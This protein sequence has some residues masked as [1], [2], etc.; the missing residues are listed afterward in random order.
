MS[1]HFR[2]NNKETSEELFDKRL[3]YDYYVNPV[4]DNLV[5]FSFAEKR[6]Y[7]RVNRDY[8]PIY[9]LGSLPIRNIP[10][11]PGKPHSAINF[12]SDA[13]AALQAEFV[14]KAAQG[15]IDTGTK[16]LSSL[17]VHKSYESPLNLY[18]KYY[19][20]YME[21]FEEVVREERILFVNFGQ[22]MNKILPY[23]MSAA[24]DN[25]FTFPGFLKSKKCSV[26]ASGLAIEIADIP[27]DNDEKKYEEFLKSNN[28][29]F[30]V[31]ACAN[32]G[33]MVDRH[34]PYR[35]VADIASAPML[36]YAQV[37]GAASTDEVLTAGFSTAHRQY[38]SRFKQIMFDFYER[39][40]VQRIR[41]HTYVNNT[42]RIVTYEPV[43]YTLD[44]ISE[45]YTDIY[46]LQ[47][48][49]KLR[50]SEE[51][52]NHTP[53]QRARLIQQT[54]SLAKTDL[55]LALD[56]FEIILNKPFDYRGS[57]TYIINARKKLEE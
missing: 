10:A 12:V 1:E 54:L 56:S 52:T 35:L 57:L 5:D 17:T 46:F 48:Y 9:L 26:L 29:N 16:Y 7:G 28:W 14:A 50:F 40:R 24:R 34:I 6:L 22:F 42:A 31:N 8:L 41:R 47:L 21:S 13:F 23:L 3:I 38:F 30:F 19:M 45:K 20:T 37:Y 44:S 51:E 49:C 11:P 36:S 25:P 39:N 2:K 27:Y 4:Y 43:K 55:G 33:F 32:Y 15:L 53:T 18:D